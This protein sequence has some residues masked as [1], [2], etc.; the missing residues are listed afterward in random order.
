MRQLISEKETLLKLYE[1]VK[2]I[3]VDT[4]AF[5]PPIFYFNFFNYAVYQNYSDQ[6]TFVLTFKRVL[7]TI[8]ISFITTESERLIDRICNF[9]G[10][11]NNQEHLDKNKEFV[12]GEIAFYMELWGWSY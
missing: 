1:K 2:K 4:F 9:F 11:D 6:N 10:Y 5:K 7:R 8:Q 3:E 12:Y